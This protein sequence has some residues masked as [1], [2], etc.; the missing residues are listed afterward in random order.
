[1][2]FGAAFRIVGALV[3]IGVLAKIIYELSI[4]SKHKLR[5]EYRFSKEFLNDLYQKKLH[6][7]AIERGYYAIAGTERI[8][9]KEIEYLLSLENPGSCL[10]GYVLSR[11]YLEHIEKNS[12]FKIEFSKKYKRKCSRLWRKVIHLAVYFVGAFI[13]FSPLL[14]FKPMDLSLNQLFTLIAVITP[15]AGFFAVNSMRCFIKISLGEKLVAS[16]K[17][18]TSIIV[19][20]S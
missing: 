14:L 15:S 9:S 10:K 17:K 3:N 20:N 5:E 1:M 18:H 2:E 19:G 8:K 11:R 7:L 6:P 12:Q 13:A 4:G 16:Q